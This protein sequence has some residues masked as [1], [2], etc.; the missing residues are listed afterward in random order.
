MKRFQFAII[1]LLSVGVLSGCGAIPSIGPDPVR[2]QPMESDKNWSGSGDPGLE[3]GSGIN[4]PGGY[5]SDLS[6]ENGEGA[7]SNAEPEHRVRFDFNSSL[8]SQEAADILTKNAQWIQYHP[9]GEVVIEGH[10]DERGTREYNLALGQQRADAVKTYLVSQGVDVTRLRVISYG[11][12]RPLVTGH[13]EFAWSQNRR[14]EIL[15]R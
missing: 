6:G 1:I 10:C 3:Q 9:G 15:V 5:G 13:D 14:A 7:G 12:E 11:K 2:T 4:R 8:V